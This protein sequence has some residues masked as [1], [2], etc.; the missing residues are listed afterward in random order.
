MAKPAETF[1]QIVE[2]GD[3]KLLL[4]AVLTEEQ[5][6][7]TSNLFEPKSRSWRGQYQSLAKAIV[8]AYNK[9]AGKAS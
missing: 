7:E 3:D 1:V 6:K 9:W 5:L 4:L 2:L 8:G